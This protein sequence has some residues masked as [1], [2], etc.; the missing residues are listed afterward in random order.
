MKPRK[1]SC[2]LCTIS[3]PLTYSYVATYSIFILAQHMQQESK[4]LAKKIAEA[5]V[6][7]NRLT[8]SHSHKSKNTDLELLASSHIYLNLVQTLD[9]STNAQLQCNKQCNCSWSLGSVGL[10]SFQL[11]QRDFVNEMN[12]QQGLMYFVNLHSAKYV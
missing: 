3:L 4:P 12:V 10:W 11:N 8:C 1:F 5:R 9:A 2:K 6:S 7:T